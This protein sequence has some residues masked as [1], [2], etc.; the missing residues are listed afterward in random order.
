MSDIKSHHPVIELAWRRQT[1]LSKNSTSKRDEYYSLRKWITYLGVAAVLFAIL[2]DTF[3]EVVPGWAS[4]ILR[5]FLIATPIVSSAIAAFGKQ[6][7]QGKQYLALRGAAEEI[8]KEIFLYRTILK[9][10]P[11]R[12]KILNDRLAKIQRTM[13]QSINGELVLK[14]YNGPIPPYYDPNDPNSDP[15][16]TDLSGDEY[17]TFRVKD[18]LDWH[19]RR[20]N[21]RHAQRRNIQ[22]WILIFGGLG[23]FLAAIGDGFAVWVALTA[24][25]TSA[26]VGW[27][28][29]RGLDETI[30]N[31]SRVVLELNIIC[32][33]W[34]TLHNH[35]KTDEEFF[36]MVKETEEVMRAQHSKWM[37]SMQENFA[38]AEGEEAELVE[39]IIQK[40]RETD[41]EMQEKIAE[42]AYDVIATAHN[43]TYERVALGVED[44]AADV[45]EHMALISEEVTD[46]FEVEAA[47]AD[48][49]EDAVLPETAVSEGGTFVD[50]VF[51]NEATP[52][53]FQDEVFDDGEPDVF[54]A[55][56]DNDE[57]DFFSETAVKEDFVDE[58]FVDEEPDDSGGVG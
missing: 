49:F 39:G 7:Q 50:E 31:Y 42:Q 36:K 5:I 17:F 55:D 56:W 4:W 43:Q 10:E 54:D 18:Q 30:A 44:A 14:P 41:Q 11:N 16:I 26:F 38:E 6:F 3:H 34:L 53:E 8:K 2:Y 22:I 45:K 1:E 35:E 24:A 12:Y 51:Q 40:A 32:D 20:I 33:R 9:N 52:T 13:F 58:V 29:I 27:E 47:L 48:Q 57:D 25:I 19:T 21:E 23:A 37:K 46:G 15:G 28:E